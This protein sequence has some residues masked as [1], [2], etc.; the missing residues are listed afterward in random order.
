MFAKL[1][2][3]K[4]IAK[5]VLQIEFELVDGELAFQPGQHLSITLPEMYYTDDRG[6]IR[7]FSLVTPPS[8]KTGFVI[9]TRLSNS[10]YKRSLLR[11]L[12]GREVYLGSVSGSLVM[13]P[14]SQPLVMIAG[15]MG[16][17]PFMSM[18]RHLAE[19]ATEAAL[20]RPVYFFYSNHNEE[21]TPFLPEL[22]SYDK[23]LNNFSLLLSMTQQADWQ[24]ETQHIDAAMIKQAVSDYKAAYY[25][26]AGP[27]TM[28]L[29]TANNFD[30]LGLKPDQYRLE[31]FVGY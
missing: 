17:T 10:A 1:K 8:Y 21:S 20:P 2:D 16:V 6:N 26:V 23:K 24:S 11:L 4:E 9:T 3:K 31:E 27:T 13:P 22:R 12:F 7:Y 30:K 29:G 25:L 5:N 15:G 14:G 19:Q 18:I 28:V